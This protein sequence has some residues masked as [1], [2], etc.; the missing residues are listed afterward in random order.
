[1]AIARQVI[2]TLR[3]DGTEIL[4]TKILAHKIADNNIVS[5]SLLTVESN[6]ICVLKSRGVVLNTYMAGQYGLTTPDK[7]L[8]GNFVQGFFSGASPWQY[9]VIYVNCAKLLVR[10]N[11][12]ATSREMAEVSYTV[13]YYI[14]ID[15]PEGA[16][17]LITHMPFDR[18]DINVDEIAAYAG[19]CIEQAVN[20]I[21][22]VTKLEDINLEIGKL[23]TTVKEH[24]GE[25]LKVYGIK[26]A[27]LKVLVL[28]K[29]ERMR[30]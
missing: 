16:L 8:I 22:Q 23:L 28:P 20:Q 5:G 30:N 19:P 26:L 25:F 10:N 17:A 3:P 6:N 2:T 18:H 4:G 7:P 12:I 21:V 13:D 14:H 9:E 27:D 29:D 15:D 1:M 11:G 24:L